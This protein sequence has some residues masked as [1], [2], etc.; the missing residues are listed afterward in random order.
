M[1]KQVFKSLR[2]AQIRIVLQAAQVLTTFLNY[3][4]APQEEAPPKT[5]TQD[6][7]ARLD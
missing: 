1:T 6:E 4:V 3:S 2:W 5:E 7:S